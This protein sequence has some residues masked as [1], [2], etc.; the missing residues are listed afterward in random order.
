[1]TSRVWKTLLA[2]GLA[3]A[4]IGIATLATVDR[5]PAHAG[6]VKHPVVLELFTS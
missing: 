2:G 6:S 1:M 5:Q 4:V 3:S